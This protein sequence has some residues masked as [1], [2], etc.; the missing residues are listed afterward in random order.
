MKIQN[1]EETT[2]ASLK[3]AVKEFVKE[4][5]WEKFHTPQNLALSISIEAAELLQIFQWKLDKNYYTEKELD[6][7]QMEVADILIYLLI[8]FNSMNWDVTQIF[9]KKMK[10][11]KEKYPCG[12][13]KEKLK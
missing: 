11:N 7:M 4:R 6:S 12:L 1:D 9:W 10:L 2:I 3:N 5:E 8:F 13:L